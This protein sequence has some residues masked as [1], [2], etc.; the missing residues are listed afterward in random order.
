[1]ELDEQII[2]ELRRLGG[3][4]PEDGWSTAVWP[5]GE[6]NAPAEMIRRVYPEY[7][8]ASDVEIYDDFG[9][10][11]GLMF[12]ESTEFGFYEDWRDFFTAVDP[13]KDVPFAADEVY[14]YFV[15]KADDG[16]GYMVSSVDHEDVRE[17]PFRRPG[18]TLGNFLSI[19][20][21]TPGTTGR[22]PEEEF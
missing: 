4:P 18:M 14:F 21:H 2:S 11:Q 10:I 19:L 22:L 8:D 12:V 5:E 13:A 3:T 6:Y 15:Y 7:A 1:M 20:D 9:M 16:S 17:E